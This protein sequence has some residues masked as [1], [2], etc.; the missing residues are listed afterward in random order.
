MIGRPETPY[1]PRRKWDKAMIFD[2]L[3]AMLIAAGILIAV[4]VFNAAVSSNAK[5]RAEENH[6]HK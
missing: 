4:S 2:F 1:P 3:K 6:E 5:K